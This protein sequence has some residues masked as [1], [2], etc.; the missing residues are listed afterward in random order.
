MYSALHKGLNYVVAPVV[1][2]IQDILTVVEKTVKLLPVEMAEEARQE[3]VRILRDSYGLRDNLAVTERRALRVLT[4]SSWH[5][6]AMP[7]W[8][9][10][11]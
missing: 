2:H 6:R 9:L 10:T 7:Q 3:T 1:L 8:Y 5:T 11:L 4:Q